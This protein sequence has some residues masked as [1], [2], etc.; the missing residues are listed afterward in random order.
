[1]RRRTSIKEDK[2]EVAF[3]NTAKQ[4]KLDIRVFPSTST[5]WT[6]AFVVLGT[7]GLIYVMNRA[8][9]GVQMNKRRLSK[10]VLYLV[11]ISKTSVDLHLSVNAADKAYTLEVTGV[12]LGHH[13]KHFQE[14]D[15]IKLVLACPNAKSRANWHASIEAIQTSIGT[16]LRTA[17]LSVGTKPCPLLKKISQ[18][19]DQSPKSP[20]TNTQ[21][22]RKQSTKSTYTTY[23]TSSIPPPPTRIAS[24]HSLYTTATVPA[25]PPDPEDTRERLDSQ[26]LGEGWD[27]DEVHRVRGSVD[28]TY[29]VSAVPGPPDARGSVTSTFTVSPVPPPPGDG[30]RG[31]V[32][33]TYTTSYVPPPDEV[34]GGNGSSGKAGTR[35]SVTSVYTTAHVPPPPGG[36]DETI[37]TN[38]YLLCTPRKEEPPLPL[39]LY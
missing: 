12:V 23:T 27:Y 16:P 5:K 36:E 34:M 21:D 8:P 28:S 25:P 15:H 13:S 11:D 37:Q 35:G 26:D 6:S 39:L 3:G 17:K 32:T 38:P 9:V 1:M 2:P 22:M 18:A 7:E 30:T 31:S 24:Q 20:T 10:G 4:E 29:T 19:G 33:S 14:G